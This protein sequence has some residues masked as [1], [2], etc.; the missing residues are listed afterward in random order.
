MKPHDPPPL[1]NPCSCPF[2]F[3]GPF[4]TARR[5]HPLAGKDER[6]RICCGCRGKINEWYFARLNYL[7]RGFAILPRILSSGSC[8]I[9]LLNALAKYFG[10]LRCLLS[11]SSFCVNNLWILARLLFCI[12]YGFIICLFAATKRGVSAGKDFV[13]ILIKSTDR[14]TSA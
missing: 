6:S 4:A 2:P 1:A 12:I 13:L 8:L 5:L 3:Q 10:Y 11:A 7:L 9:V 14:R